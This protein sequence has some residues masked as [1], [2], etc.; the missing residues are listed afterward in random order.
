M[1]AYRSNNDQEIYPRA[2][3]AE[4]RSRRKPVARVLILFT[5]GE[6][7]RTSEVE[8]S[9]NIEGAWCMGGHLTDLKIWLFARSEEGENTRNTCMQ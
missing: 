8:S 5:P 4:R 6:K 9:S 3:G 1:T 2:N 7:E